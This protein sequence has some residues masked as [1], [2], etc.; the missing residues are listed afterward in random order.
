VAE[1]DARVGSIFVV[2]PQSEA[3]PSP[4][5]NDVL[6]VP[7]TPGQAMRLHREWVFAG[8]TGTAAEA[9]ESA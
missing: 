5:V 2:V 3:A 9:G 1:A 4:F 6:E 8:V 7:A